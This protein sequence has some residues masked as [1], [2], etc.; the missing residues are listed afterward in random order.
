[1]R[2]EQFR[3]ENLKEVHMET[4]AC[5]GTYYYTGFERNRGSK[6]LSCFLVLRVG[7]NVKTFFGFHK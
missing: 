5:M 7:A 1:M 6:L 3:S 4:K 2:N